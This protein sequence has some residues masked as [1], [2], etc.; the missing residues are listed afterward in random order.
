MAAMSR[1][2]PSWEVQAQMVVASVVA[3]ETSGRDVKHSVVVE[4]ERSALVS[5][6]SVRS[7]VASLHESIRCCVHA[8]PRPLF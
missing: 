3:L 7:P 2:D 4:E 6:I 1:Q 8:N 5:I